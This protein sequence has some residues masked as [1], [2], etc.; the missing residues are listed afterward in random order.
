MAMNSTTI[1][2]NF[3]ERLRKLVSAI[4]M[5]A[6]FVRMANDVDVA[7]WTRAF[8]VMQRAY[9]MCD[10]L[11]RA[12]MMTR[13]VAGNLLRLTRLQP[14]RRLPRPVSGDPLWVLLFPLEEAGKHQD[15]RGRS[16]WFG[17]EPRLFH[18]FAKYFLGFLGW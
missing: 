3:L 13:V 11:C 5:P 17:G 12:P 6:S 2:A 10:I 1:A 14:L 16:L 8:N 18:P 9:R 7:T 15:V 4:D